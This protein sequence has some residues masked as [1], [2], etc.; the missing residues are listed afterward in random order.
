MTK[1]MSWVPAVA[2]GLAV[3]LGMSVA[4]VAGPGTTA[5]ATP[6]ALTDS[7]TAVSP[8]DPLAVAPPEEYEL[9]PGDVDTSGTIGEAPL[10]NSRSTGSAITL[11]FGGDIHFE[12][13][14]RRQQ[15]GMA[16][17]SGLFGAADLSMINLETALTNR[18]SAQN[19]EYRFR[20]SASVLKTLQR[21]GI[22]VVTMA[23]NHA[24]DFGR[25]GL[26]DTL[27]ARSRSK[28]PVVGLGND[29]TDAL[30][31]WTTKIGDTSF[32]FF[33]AMNNEPLSDEH[34]AARITRGW[35]ATKRAP[36]IVIT[37][38]A[39][40]ALLS[41]VRD[42]AQ[43][44]DVVVV[45][46]HWGIE[47][48]ACPSARQTAFMQQLR[49]A[50]ADVIIGAHPHVLEGAGFVGS[51]AVA[52]S[53]GNFVWYNTFSR[54]SAVLQVDIVKGKPAKMSYI[55]VAIGADGLPRRVGGEGARWVRAR[56]ASG[57]KCAHLS[58]E[59]PKPPAD[60]PQVKRR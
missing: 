12:N 58:A 22:D 20:A 37:P 50:G 39:K 10:F 56:M 38:G 9:P 25:V 49:A 28:L 55:P 51:T 33:G 3:A 14:V 60:S 19:K 45:Y 43:K 21:R 44:Q 53:L 26:A 7:G 42:A 15:H 52:Y 4:L 1:K 13:Q 34:N 30:T 17:L 54:Y 35:T 6:Q 40:H 29:I 11:R 47:G 18:G 16:T 46:M 41:A 36:G 2:S 31:P 59:P 32:A 57:A 23:N 5:S 8:E 48:S 27:R 24:L